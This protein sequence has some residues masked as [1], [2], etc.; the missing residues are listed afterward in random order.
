MG[1]SAKY[2]SIDYIPRRGADC[3]GNGKINLQVQTKIR[4]EEL[5]TD[6]AMCLLKLE[7]AMPLFQGIG[8]VRCFIITKS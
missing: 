4:V 1:S 7:L 8:M 2:P 5:F 6:R 3:P